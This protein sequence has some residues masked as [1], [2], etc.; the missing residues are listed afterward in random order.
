[1]IW[2]A[3]LAAAFYILW[4]YF[5]QDIEEFK[6]EL[7][8]AILEEDKREAIERARFEGSMARMRIRGLRNSQEK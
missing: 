6:H 3:L 4:S 1:M 8:V 2:L 5:R 7:D